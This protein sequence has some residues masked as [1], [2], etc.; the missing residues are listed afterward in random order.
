MQ[1]TEYVEQLSQRYAQNGHPEN[2]GQMA[3]YMKHK[4]AF[5]GIKTPERQQLSKQ[6]IQQYGRPEGSTLHQV[7]RLCFEREEREMHYFI[8][9]LL[10]P[11]IRK[12]EASLLPL[13]EELILKK[14]W[15]DSV[16]FL[17]PKLA[18]PLFQ[19]YPS[20]FEPYVRR[21]ITSENIW[22]QRSAILAQLDYKEATD[23]D[24]LFELISIRADSEAF[25]VR[26]AAGW[27]LRSYSKV[28]PQAVC[29]FVDRNQLSK[30]TVR[31]GSKYI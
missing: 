29:E 6:H 8:R 17:A 14:P 28:N 1:A 7:C 21:W 20:T 30:R 2:A 31:E 11:V 19:K 23:A 18:G 24:L 26:K 5:F 16:D 3:A 25:F 9:D 12:Q 22:L 15:W 13:L 4:F 10:R 27:A